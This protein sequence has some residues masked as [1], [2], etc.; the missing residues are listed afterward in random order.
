M[1]LNVSLFPS[2]THV[3]ADL[4]YG[5]TWDELLLLLGEHRPWPSKEAGPMY[6]AAEWQPGHGPSKQEG[7]RFLVAVHFG[8]FD[9]DNATEDQI[10]E[11]VASLPCR[12]ALLS[13]FSHGTFGEGK[14]ARFDAEGN[15]VRL[16]KFRI[17]LEYSR[18]VLKSEHAHLWQRVNE[19][20]LRGLADTSCKDP[21]HRYFF[22]SH[23]EGP[24]VPP[25]RMLGDGPPLDVQGMLGDYVARI[26]VDDGASDGGMPTATGAGTPISRDQL[27][28]IAETLVSS[29]Q[30]AWIGQALRLV[31][32][33]EEYAPKG[34]GPNGEPGRHGTTYR[35]VCE[36]RDR[37]P[38]V[39]GPGL[40]AHFAPSLAVMQPTHVTEEVICEML[41]GKQQAALEAQHHRIVEAFAR[42]NPGRSSVYTEEELVGFSERLAVPRDRLRHRWVIQH[43]GSFYLFCDGRYDHYTALD[44][45]AAASRDLAPAISAGVDLMVATQRSVR[46]KTASELVQDYGVA[47]TNVVVDFRAQ[48]ASYDDETTTMTEAPCPVRVKPKY[49][50]EI[51]KWIDLLGGP[52][53]ARLNQWLAATTMLDQPCAALYMEGAPNA[54]KTLLALGVTRLWTTDRPATLDEALGDFNE[55]IMRC[56]LIFGDEVAPVDNR[57]KLRTPELREI[58][59]ARQRPLKRKFKPNATIKGCVRIILAAN[60]TNLLD[61]TEHLTENDIAAIVERFFYLPCQP[62]AAAYLRDVGPQAVRPWIDEDMIAQHC[63][64]LSEN[65]EV[66]KTSRFLVSGDASDLSRSLA[67][68]TGLRAVVCQWLVGYLL[69]PNQFRASPQRHLIRVRGGKLYVNVQALVEN[70]RLYLPDER[71]TPT[72]AALA[73]ALA[74]LSQEAWQ[75]DLVNPERMTRFRKVDDSLLVEWSERVGYADEAHLRDQMR[76]LDEENPSRVN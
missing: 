4:R 2:I 36:V 69:S 52:K 76:V 27:R 60:N 65:I 71:G 28:K 6:S 55:Q 44:V 26:R 53:A 19:T 48:Y 5:V 33:G 74:G 1:A 32:K 56:P 10:V 63:L 47:A 23:P 58:I 21:G 54:G 38:L 25:V 11:I 45:V 40:A 59:Q 62:I 51:A 57:G 35:I 41:R 67:S 68:G 61:T 66:P 30:K 24:E 34:G 12:Y 50:K 17:L 9:L 18:P 20:L 16:S 64:W 42:T 15:K 75:R 72:A 29:K 13:T 22:P 70:W 39:D 46:P 43:G 8:C 49:H 37:Y 7:D 73:R 31:L 14:K 3:R